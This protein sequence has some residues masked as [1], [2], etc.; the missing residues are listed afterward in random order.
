MNWEI[1]GVLAESLSAVAVLATLIY[2]ATQI[3]ETRK[4]LQISSH[5]VRTDRNIHLSLA[6]TQDELYQKVLRKNRSGEHL[7]EEELLHAGMYWAAAMRHFE[8]LH[9]QQ[10]LGAIDDATWGA[11]KAGIA[12]T[13]STPWGIYMWEKQV[14]NFRKPFVVLVDEIRSEGA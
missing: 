7:S 6:G 11:N 3:K 12:L 13:M 5:Q 9:Y 10:E 4:H 2:L 1:A 8:D 14:K